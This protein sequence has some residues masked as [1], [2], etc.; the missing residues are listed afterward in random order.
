MAFIKKKKGNKI[1]R[2]KK[3]KEWLPPVIT[4]NKGYET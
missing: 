4:L 2:Y 1:K 3:Q